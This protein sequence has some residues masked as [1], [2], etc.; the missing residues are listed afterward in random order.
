M[1][2]LMCYV[3]AD[4]QPSPCAVSTSGLGT[5]YSPGQSALRPGSHPCR[6]TDRSVNAGTVTLTK[7]TKK[8]DGAGE[9]VRGRGAMI[10]KSETALYRLADVHLVH[11][12]IYSGTGAS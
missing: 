3:P 1:I 10:M 6:G 2:N 8:G 7:M 11:T 12:F 9:R 4:R 5:R